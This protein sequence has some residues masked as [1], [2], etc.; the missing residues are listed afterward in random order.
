MKFRKDSDK[1]HMNEGMRTTSYLISK[2]ER[3]WQKL[4]FQDAAEKNKYKMADIGES[5]DL[6]NLKRFGN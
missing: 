1:V 6:T 2:S 4:K 3:L 5:L